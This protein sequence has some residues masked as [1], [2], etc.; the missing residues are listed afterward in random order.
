MLYRLAI[1][2]RQPTIGDWQSREH[3]F[4]DS[5]IKGS[6]CLRA[7][8]AR[9]F[10]MEAGVAAGFVAIAELW[11]VG[12]FYDS[13]RIHNLIELALAKSFPVQVLNIAL[14]VH[15]A[16][17]AFREGPYI[18]DWITPGGFS[19]IAGCGTS[20]DLTRPL[21]YNL[22]DK[23]HRD[24]FPAVQFQTW[25][26]DIP[27]TAVGREEDIFEVLANSGE[28]FVHGMAKLGLNMSTK[29]VVVASSPDLAKRM[30]NRLKE[31]GKDVQVA[32]SGADLGADCVAGGARRITLQTS[33][34][35]KVRAGITHTLKFGRCTK[36][37]RTRKLIL[38]GVLPKAYGFLVLGCSPTA[39]SA[40]RSAIVKGLCIQKPSGCATTALESNGFGAKDPLIT[41]AIDNIL[42]FVQ[43]VQV[44]GW[45]PSTQLAWNNTVAWAK[46]GSR[47]GKVRGP[48]GACISTLL[49]RGWTPLQ[50]NIWEDPAG[51]R[52]LGI[53]IAF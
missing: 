35:K 11:D 18:S 29:S 15:T 1:K 46:E 24:F 37:L 50:A 8:L 42:G 21:L 13:I 53:S 36:G 44:E 43:A 9:A 19:I 52:G 12:A 23:L 40:L 17:R 5:A 25:V 7:A 30:Q 32:S 16:S 51:V 39:A 31:A 2:M 10:R 33:R 49:D 3:G 20:V 41:T 26:D 38:T 22:T 47:W 4:W 27:Q 34:M 14:A 28:M 48:M 45:S 6:S